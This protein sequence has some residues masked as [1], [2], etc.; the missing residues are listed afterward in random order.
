MSRHI[1]IQQFTFKVKSLV[2]ILQRG[3]SF[4]F[5]FCVNKIVVPCPFLHTPSMTVLEDRNI[6]NRENENERIFLIPLS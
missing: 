5:H 4:T 1:K 2:P 6:D 3:N